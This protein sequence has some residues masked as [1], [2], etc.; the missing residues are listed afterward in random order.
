MA[1][2]GIRFTVIFL[3]HYGFNRNCSTHAE[4]KREIWARA[5]S[6]KSKFGAWWTLLPP[7]RAERQPTK[8]KNPGNARRNSEKLSDMEAG[9]V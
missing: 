4:K 1:V 3:A 5:A 6:S 8:Q 2:Q 7:F 9:G